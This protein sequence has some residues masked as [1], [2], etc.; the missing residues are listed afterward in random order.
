M[1]TIRSDNDMVSA[2]IKFCVVG[3]FLRQQYIC[4]LSNVT[5]QIT[6]RYTAAMHIPGGLMTV[7]KTTVFI[8]G[9]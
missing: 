8:D 5:L 6:Y 2:P 7:S 4:L 9:N 1:H 3:V